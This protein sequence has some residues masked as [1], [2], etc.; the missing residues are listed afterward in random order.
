MKAALRGTEIYYDIAG[1]QLAPERNGLVERPVIFMLHGGPGGDHTRYKQHSVELQNFAQLVFID[2]RGCGRSKKTKAS[3]YTLENNIED[4]EALRKH[5]GLEKIC[6]LG[7]SYGGMVAQGYATRYPKRVEKLI[8]VATAPSYRFI[9][10]AQAYLQIHGTPQQIRICQHIW[11]GTFKNSNHVFKMFL[12]MQ[13]LYSMTAK[14]TPKKVSTK[15]QYHSDYAVEALNEGFGK[16]L[17]HFDFIPKLHKITCPTL[18]L[19]GDKD[20]ICRPAQSQLM[21]EKIPHATLKIFK[22]CGH[23]IA[24]DAHEKYIKIIKLFLQG[25]TR[26][27]TIRQKK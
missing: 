3:D 11:N 18:V 16:F 24:I 19:G 1:M 12:I 23:S 13:P 7:T 22:N 4:I 6:I 27:K 9:P 20:W 21:A 8:L 25:S 14:L 15:S 2:H 17:R 10:A 26:Q 5:L